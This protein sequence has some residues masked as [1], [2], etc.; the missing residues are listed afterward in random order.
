MMIRINI[1][2][3]AYGVP[4]LLI[5]LG[6]ITIFLGDEPFSSF[7]NLIGYGWD[8]IGIGAFLYALEIILAVFGLHA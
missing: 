1:K 5:G 7:S 3:M 8:M 6:W 4:A 2:V